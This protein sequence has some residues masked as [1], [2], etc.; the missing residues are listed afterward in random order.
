MTHAEEV[1]ALRLQLHAAE[2]DLRATE[3]RLA[4]ERRRAINEAAQVAHASQD[5]CICRSEGYAC[6]ACVEAA[7]IEGRIR[8]L[9]R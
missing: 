4:T 6:S 3:A 2:S 5:D 9:V 8:A 1:E 7:R